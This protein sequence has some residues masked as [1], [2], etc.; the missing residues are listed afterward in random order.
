VKREQCGELL[1]EEDK[2]LRQQANPQYV[3]DVPLVVEDVREED[4]FAS[5]TAGMLS[6][7]DDGDV[8]GSEFVTEEILRGFF[9]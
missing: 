2:K 7:Q 6:E 1:Y 4:L 8:E 3:P 5:A 9:E